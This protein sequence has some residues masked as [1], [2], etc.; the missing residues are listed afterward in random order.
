MSYSTTKPQKAIIKAIKEFVKGEFVKE[1]ILEQEKKKGEF[2]L[3]TWKKIMEL[4]FIGIHMPDKYGGGGMGMIENIL[5][6]ET[7]ARCD[8]TLG[9]SLMFSL[10]GIESIAYLGDE[11][12]KETFLKPLLEGTIRSGFLNPCLIN[13]RSGDDLVMFRKMEDAWV[14]DGQI[15]GMI[16][17]PEADIYILPGAIEESQDDLFFLL[18]EASSSNISIANKDETLGLRMTPLSTVTFKDV[19]IPLKNI[20]QVKKKKNNIIETMKSELRLL[21]SGLA[22]GIAKGA[23]DRAITH[24]KQRKQFGVKLANFQTLQHK[25]AQMQIKIKQADNL[26]YQAAT[27]Y[28]PKKPDFISIASSVIC[29]T[30]TAVEV[31]NDAIQLLGGYGY[32]TEYNVERYYRDAKTLQIMK[33]NRSDLYDDIAKA[34][35]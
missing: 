25:L 9:T 7:L 13:D 8:S 3:E 19:S 26:T 10:S 21:V 28:N 33:G 34:V 30:D 22:I 11:N 18:I 35:L 23:M 31:S 15:S 32:T 27:N 5:V 4:G 29:A 20:I 6:A 17:S 1:L 2:P 14:I 12:Q 16:N 24:V